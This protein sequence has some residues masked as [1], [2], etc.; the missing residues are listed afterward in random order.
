MFV[1]GLNPLQRPSSRHLDPEHSANNHPRSP[2]VRGVQVTHL[3]VLLL[4]HHTR[5]DLLRVPE[6]LQQI[7]GQLPVQA[8]LRQEHVL[9]RPRGQRR[10]Q[11]PLVWSLPPLSSGLV[12][13]GGGGGVTDRQHL[14]GSRSL[15]RVP[16][17]HRLH[18]V[19]EMS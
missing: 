8:L 7:Q 16:H 15:L 19:V 9:P 11:E 14:G 5:F 2:Q 3:H 17:Q 10:R 6:L 12:L 1:D 13:G 4:H 18:K